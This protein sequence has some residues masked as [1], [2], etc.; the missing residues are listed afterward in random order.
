M[1]RSSDEKPVVLERMDAASQE[2]AESALAN[3][4]RASQKNVSRAASSN[5]ACA[6]ESAS[7]FSKSAQ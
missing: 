1:A 5:G 6:A 7:T 3:F 2:S 4:K